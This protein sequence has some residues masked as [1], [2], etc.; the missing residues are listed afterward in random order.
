MG[1][2]GAMPQLLRLVAAFGVAKEV[3]V[4]VLTVVFVVVTVVV[5]VVLEVVIISFSFRD[6]N[7]G[8]G[9]LGGLV[10]FDLKLVHSLFSL[11]TSLEISSFSRSQ[12][13][14][15]S[16]FLLGLTSKFIC[17]LGFDFIG[18]VGLVGFRVKTFF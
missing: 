5:V 15:S 7:R 3:V 18:L 11:D 16:M 8:F 12:D 13:L 1:L 6:T 17:L 10:G 9:G 4:V 2:S 14:I